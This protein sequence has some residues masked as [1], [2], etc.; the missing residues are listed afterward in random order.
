VEAPTYVYGCIEESVNAVSG[1]G[2]I[3]LVVICP[4][5]PKHAYL[6]YH[7][8][9]PGENISLMSVTAVLT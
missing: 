8:G 1:A 3:I 5:N 7:Y 2:G 9:Q 6:A 4:L